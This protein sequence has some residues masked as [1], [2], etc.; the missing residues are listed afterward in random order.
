MEPMPLEV[1]LGSALSLERIRVNIPAV[2]TVAVGGDVS[3][4]QLAAQRLLGLSQD[5]IS[6][7]ARE[8]ITG[9]L[10]AVVAQ[11]DIDQINQDRDTFNRMIE[12]LVGKEL[13]KIGL[14][15]VNVN[16][17][18]IS[19]ASGKIEAQGKKAAAESIE[20]ARI[21][22]ALERRKGAAGVAEADK[23]RETEVAA[24]VAE[25]DIG[26]K[27]A[28]LN[29]RSRIAEIDATVG[30]NQLSLLLYTSGNAPCS[31]ARVPDSSRPAIFAGGRG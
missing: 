21:A 18:D 27:Q 13:Q 28:E 26:M 1:K 22:E 29:Q 5:E 4:H 31:L 23:L 12:E 9:Q 25:R 24:H 16:I 15:L 3:Y 7:Q 6:Y 17:T 11:M 20:K 14:E 30:S 2:F 19:D 10:R 8:I